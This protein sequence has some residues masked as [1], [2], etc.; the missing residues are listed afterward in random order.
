MG[1]LKVHE[2]TCIP[3]YI[4][5]QSQCYIRLQSFR[6][7]LWYCILQC[8]SVAHCSL[9]HRLWSW[10]WGVHGQLGLESV[11]NKLLPTHASL[12]DA[13]QVSFISAGYGH[14]AVLT[15][16]VMSNVVNSV[17][18]S[19]QQSMCILCYVTFSSA[20]DHYRIILYWIISSWFHSCREK[21]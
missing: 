10:G 13:W 4:N 17:V 1:E 14:S 18:E 2:C 5:I 19:V 7:L 15:A 8:V 6:L 3:G 11:D 21:F 16:E 20:S 9:N 12:L